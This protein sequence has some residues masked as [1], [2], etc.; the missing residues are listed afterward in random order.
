MK[1]RAIHISREFD[2]PRALVFE[3]FSQHEH[4][5]KWWGPDG[6][7]TS[8]KSMAF[9][10]GGEWIFTMHGPDGT[11]YP[12]RVVYT[13]ID[14]PKLLKYDHFAN[15]EDNGEPPHFKTTITFKEANGKTTIEINMLFP[16][17]KKREQAAEFG[18][19]EG[20]HQTLTRLSEFLTN[21]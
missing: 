13:E 8:T 17:A 1:D 18:A 6:F 12:N 7:S 4:I 15:Y 3:A 2:A 21:H 9:A 11:D 20:G 16:T 14:K 10:I 19:V 5:G